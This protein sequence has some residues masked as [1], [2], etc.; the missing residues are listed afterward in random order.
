VRLSCE[1]GAARSGRARQPRAHTHATA[2]GE[3]HTHAPC[4]R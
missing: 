3:S 4:W 1:A 2:L